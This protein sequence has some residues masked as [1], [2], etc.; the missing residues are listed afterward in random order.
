MII[1]INKLLYVCIYTK[2]IFSRMAKSC[3]GSIWHHHNHQLSL[4]LTTTILHDDPSATTSP[5]LPTTATLHNCCQLTTTTTT[6]HTDNTSN[7][8]TMVYFTLPHI[9]QLDS[10]WSPDGFLESKWSPP[11]IQPNLYISGSSSWSPCGVCIDSR[12]TPPKSN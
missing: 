9:L 10:T 5:L 6:S 4:F 2:S 8:T 3:Q 12:W 7:A 1:N 11:G